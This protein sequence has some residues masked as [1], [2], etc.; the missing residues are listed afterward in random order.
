MQPGSATVLGTGL[1]GAS[2]G[3]ALR[4]QGWEVAGW[5][6]DP[7]A[8]RGALH[9]GAFNA[10]RDDLD[11]EHTDLVVLASP[12]SAIIATLQ[13]MRT[14]HLVTDIAGVKGPI[15]AAAGHLDHFV[16]GH[17]MAGGESSGPGLASSTLFHGATWILTSDGADPDDLAGLEELVT[18]FGANPKV[19]TAAEHD[20]AV[21]RVS[22]LPHL[23]AAALMGMASSDQAWLTL[24]GTGFRDLTRI[25]A[26]DSDWW[27]E[28]LQ[29]NAEQVG[30]TIDELQESLRVW[31]ETLPDGEGLGERLGAARQARAGLG[32]HHTQV[33]VVLLDRPG[34]IARVG[35]ALEASR[36]DVRDF[37]L[38]HGEH[39]GGGIL[40]ISVKG[41]G[42][43]SLK[44]ALVEEGFEVTEGA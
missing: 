40:T 16:G 11:I 27:A 35:H 26:S 33:R 15:V 22:H 7:E 36:V 20:A 44:Q 30:A 10:V 9:R 39:G 28:V 3:L 6:P 29:A 32:E 41:P 37:Q 13:D 42:T 31:K 17:P 24:A 23:L 1:L 43:G 18:S 21:A 12:P 38:R 34:E 2:V 8:L 5:D 25:A 19:M 14:D 4:S